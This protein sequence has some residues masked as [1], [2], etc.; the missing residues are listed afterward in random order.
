MIKKARLGST[1]ARHN[2]QSGPSGLNPGPPRSS[3]PSSSIPRSS[4]SKIGSDE[5]QSSEEGED[6]S[7]DDKSSES[8]SDGTEYSDNESQLLS[9][10]TSAGLRKKL[11]R[12]IQKEKD[13]GG[14]GSIR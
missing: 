11:H 4:G 5:H 13:E 8:E 10:T 6:S 2:D 1:P 7:D 9:D 3:T 12:Y 14:M